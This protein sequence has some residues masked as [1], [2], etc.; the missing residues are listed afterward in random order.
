MSATLSPQVFSILSTLVEE[1]L[2]LHYGVEDEALFADKLMSRAREAGFESA[3]DYYYFLRYDPGAAAE[4]DALTDVLVVG[5]TYFFRELD[6]LR[7]AVAHVLAPAVKERGTARVWCAGCATGEEPLSLAMVLDEVGLRSQCRI[8]ATDISARSLSKAREGSYGARSLRALPPEPTPSGFSA[9]LGAVA[10]AGLARDAR[11]A[12]RASRS[13]I[14]S[15]E[16]KQLNLLDTAA[17]AALGSFDLILCRNVLIYF[18]DSTVKSVVSSLARALEPHGRLLVG[19]SE[20]LLRFGT[21][22]RC[23]ERGGAFMYAKE[24]A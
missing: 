9:G 15:I 19:A 23:E 16:Y 13:L 8:V 20:S 7:A 2:G 18:A 17:I 3:L 4:L 5:E 11:G 22:L 1:R 21:V 24:C 10:A 6:P 14:A 12:A